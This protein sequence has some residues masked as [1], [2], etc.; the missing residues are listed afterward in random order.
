MRKMSMPGFTGEASLGKA[1]QHYVLSPG[2][3]ARA[4]SVG[5]NG[6]VIPQLRSFSP[7]LACA[8]ACGGDNECWGWCVFLYGAAQLR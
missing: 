5:A 6:R 4:V 3:A 7:G 8:M 1:A 2:A